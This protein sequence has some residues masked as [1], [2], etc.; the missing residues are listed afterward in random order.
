MA[1]PS[2]GNEDKEGRVLALAACTWN[3]VARDC[4]PRRPLPFIYLS[5]SALLAK[6]SYAA[7]FVIIIIPGAMRMDSWAA[8]V[9]L[10]EY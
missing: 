9:L 7:L 4:F 1:L 6:D 2:P 3:G 5:A 10:C 8:R